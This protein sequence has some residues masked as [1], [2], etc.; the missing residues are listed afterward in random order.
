MQMNGLVVIVTGSSR[1]L[2]RAIAKEYARQGARVV[3]TARPSSPTGLPSTIHQ[4]VDDI[5]G[6]GGE[7]LPVPCDVSDEEQVRAMVQ[8]VKHHYGQIDVLVNNAGL[9]YPPQAP[10]GARPYPMGRNDGR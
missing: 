8:Q 6:E 4:T 3:V 5:R 9:F 2:G 1:G 7:A 10:V